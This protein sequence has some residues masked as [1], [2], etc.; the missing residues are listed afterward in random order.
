MY[1]RIELDD[2][3]SL[4]GS[5][6][7]LKALL[8]KVVQNYFP[9]KKMV[10]AEWYGFNFIREDPLLDWRSISAWCDVSSETSHTDEC[11]QL[12]ET[13]PPSKLLAKVTPTMIELIRKEREVSYGIT[14]YTQKYKNGIEVE[15]SQLD[16][17][18]RVEFDFSKFLSREASAIE[19]L[20][21]AWSNAQKLVA[22]LKHVSLDIG[23]KATFNLDET[24]AKGGVPESSPNRLT[25][26][27]GGSGIRTCLTSILKW[28]MLC[29]PLFELTSSNLSLQLLPSDAAKIS[30]QL[31]EEFG[32]QLAIHFD[33]SYRPEYHPDQVLN[34]FPPEGYWVL[35][36]FAIRGGKENWQTIVFNLIQTPKERFFE[37]N[38]ANEKYLEKIKGKVEFKAYEG[39]AEKRWG[40]HKL[41]KRK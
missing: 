39:A 8:P 7:T 28:A 30:Q 18:L 32:K 19:S 26:S 15:L 10:G 24:R 21:L 9:Y 22:D 17:Q 13:V 1:V 23:K 40:L 25:L 29:E 35:P 33:G 16:K 38:V 6:K 12:L 5:L 11:C 41:R 14:F 37:A 20:K 3:S 34:D 36:M 4:E 27:H 31:S 2:P